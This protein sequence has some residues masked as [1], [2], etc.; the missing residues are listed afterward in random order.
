MAAKNLMET[1]HTLRVNGSLDMEAGMEAGLDIIESFSIQ[2]IGWNF[3]DPF[4]VSI[5]AKLNLYDS[6]IPMIVSADILSSMKNEGGKRPAKIR[7]SE[8]NWEGYRTIASREM[9][10]MQRDF[11]L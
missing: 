7:S 8:V 4:P 9:E 11:E 10:F 1:T 2:R 5:A 6:S 3:S